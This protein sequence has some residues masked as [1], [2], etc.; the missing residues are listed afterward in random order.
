MRTSRGANERS[1]SKV[2]IHLCSATLKIRFF[3]IGSCS[4]LFENLLVMISY[5]ARFVGNELKLA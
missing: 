2:A 1:L 5:L 4:K 3:E